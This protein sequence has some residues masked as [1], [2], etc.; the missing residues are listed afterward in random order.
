MVS[1]FTE[2]AVFG[3][4]YIDS[5]YRYVFPTHGELALTHLLLCAHMHL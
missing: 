1:L 2:H 4:R 3:H 5:T